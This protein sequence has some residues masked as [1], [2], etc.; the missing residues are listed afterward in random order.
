M[1][2][3]HHTSSLAHARSL[4]F[5]GENPLEGTKVFETD[6]LF[7]PRR[8]HHFDTLNGSRVPP[9]ASPSKPPMTGSP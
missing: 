1:F 4:E 6:P 2:S 7:I 5:R 3:G 8:P 9:I